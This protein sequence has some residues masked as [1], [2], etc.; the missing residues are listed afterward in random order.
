[1]AF[2]RTRRPRWLAL[3]L[4]AGLMTLSLVPFGPGLALS[5]PDTTAPALTSP[6]V[7]APAPAPV[8]DAVLAQPD[9]GERPLSRQLVAYD[10]SVRWDPAQ[11]QMLGRERVR[12]EN[13][14]RKPVGELYWHLYWNAFR[15]DKTTFMKESGG[16]LRGDRMPEGG[17]GSIDLTAARLAGSPTGAAPG[18]D[19]TSR[20]RY[21]APDDNNP[22][23]RTV[24]VLTLPRPV[25]PGGSVELEM[26]WKAVPPGIFARAGLAGSFLMAGQWFP[27]LA[28]YEPAGVRRRAEEGWNAHQYHASSEFY[29]DFGRYQ[30]RITVPQGTPVAATGALTEAPKVNDDGTVTYL[31][32]QEDVHDFAW[33]AAPGFLE[34]RATV[35]QAD[36]SLVEAHY[37][38]PAQA[39]FSLE[40]QKR[41][42]ETSLQWASAHYGPYPYR[43]LTVVTPPP[44]ASGAA[45]ME[46]PTLITGDFPPGRGGTADA[47]LAMVLAHEFMHQYFYGLVASN[48]FEEAWLDE[49]FTTYATGR[50][51]EELVSRHILPDPILTDIDALQTRHG[52]A[53]ARQGRLDQVSWGYPSSASY[54]GNVYGREA[55]V[56]RGLQYYLGTDTMDRVMR[57]YVHRWSFRHPSER[58]F[59]AVASEVSGQPLAWFFDQF[60]RGTG[61]VDYS[62]ASVRQGQD[63][64]H[65]RLRRLSGDALPVRF[66]VTLQDGRVLNEA[67]DGRDGE[68]E[69]VLPV[70]GAPVR[71]DVDPE[72]LN[73]LDTNWTNN[74]WSA[75][76]A[77]TG[78]LYWTGIATQLYQ[79]LLVRLGQWL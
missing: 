11:R 49:G 34:R 48:E 78:H 50:I 28:V 56:L 60:F 35:E 30:V 21:V 10:I 14:G 33:A 36:G 75:G 42:V 24:A 8:E 9:E 55:C 37:F 44:D 45:G 39:S 43:T 69:F 72:R 67:W 46:Y 54:A 64:L 62:V 41:I 25:P 71:V 68:R 38:L 66:Q 1:M 27:K 15:D 22:D 74:S 2:Y 6:E 19:L 58:D 31:Y 5:Q 32:Q 53:F 3:V 70:S 4:M 77:W 20:L 16:R 79:M 51:V 7:G 65:V 76:P 17:W 47:S 52:M 26:E 13:P 29:A 23:D 18:A 59:E 57:E 40:T 63:G 12:W 61:W 73:W